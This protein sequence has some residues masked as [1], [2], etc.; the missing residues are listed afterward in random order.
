MYQYTSFTVRANSRMMAMSGDK[1]A[2]DAPFLAHIA[3]P[4]AQ[5]PFKHVEPQ[6][7]ATVPKMGIWS[8]RN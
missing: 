4:A 3:N 6:D 1:G 2:Q 8:G 5:D 7:S